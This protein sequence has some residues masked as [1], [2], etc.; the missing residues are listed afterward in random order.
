MEFR[1]FI[2]KTVHDKCKFIAEEA[3]QMPTTAEDSGNPDSVYF[4]MTDEDGMRYDIPM[5]SPLNPGYYFKYVYYMK[6]KETSPETFN[7][8]INWD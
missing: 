3:N 7:K 8:I 5:L 4:N 1:D 2:Q 6:L